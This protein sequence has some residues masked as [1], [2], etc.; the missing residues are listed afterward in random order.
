M[1]GEISGCYNWAVHVLS[2]SIVSDSVPMDCG[3]PG[4]SVHGILQARILEWVAMPFPRGIFPTQGSNPRLS[5]LLYGQAGSLLLSHRESQGGEGG[6]KVRPSPG[7]RIQ[8]C[9]CTSLGQDMRRWDFPFLSFLS[10]FFKFVITHE[11]YHLGNVNSNF[12]S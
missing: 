8:D 11:L 7:L 10:L 2:H 6:V 4:S 3:P 9:V 12:S 5:C 1:S